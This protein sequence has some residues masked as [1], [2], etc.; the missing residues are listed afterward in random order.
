MPMKPAAGPAPL[1]ELSRREGNQAEEQCDDEF[2]L[3]DCSYIGAMICIFKNC[4]IP[5]S[6]WILFADEYVCH[7]IYFCNGKN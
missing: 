2:R 6:D 4:F 1:L 3:Y 5:D 7:P